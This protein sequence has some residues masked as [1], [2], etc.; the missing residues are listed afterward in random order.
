MSGGVLSKPATPPGQHNSRLQ[1]QSDLQAAGR[2]LAETSAQECSCLAWAIF[3][4]LERR[5]KQ[6]NGRWPSGWPRDALQFR[7]FIWDQIKKNMPRF[8]K[9]LRQNSQAT[10][11][12]LKKSDRTLVNLL[13]DKYSKPGRFMSTFEMMVASELLKEEGIIL[14]NYFTRGD[15]ANTLAVWEMPTSS[16]EHG[17]WVHVCPVD[18]T[19]LHVV[20]CNVLVNVHYERC[21]T[22]HRETGWKPGPLRE[23]M[24]ELASRAHTSL[25][26]FCIMP[27][28]NDRDAL[29]FEG[30]TEFTEEAKQLFRPMWEQ[31]R[32]VRRWAPRE[33]PI[34]VWTPTPTGSPSKSAESS[35][36][37]Q[38][39]F[40]ADLKRA[41]EES[42][43]TFS[44]EDDQRQ[45]MDRHEAAQID[46]II[47]KSKQEA[48]TRED[49]FRSEMEAVTQHMT[50]QVD[51]KALDVPGDGWCQQHA[52]LRCLCEVEPHNA[53]TVQTLREAQVSFMESEFEH[54]KDYAVDKEY[55]LN[56]AD[57]PGSW[58]RYC[59]G[60]RCRLCSID[61]ML[62]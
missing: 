53:W 15:F 40:D 54:Y 7:T 62:C 49:K 13:A 61:P 33:N 38:S 9:L 4:E 36:P 11:A 10:D 32:Q 50:A 26:Q 45:D 20:I 17:R 31:A 48:R 18:V 47:E 16:H 22:V 37:E 56:A 43:H 12:E 34:Q 29:G 58:Q 3:G 1:I 52:L 46:A 42:R 14:V 44:Q 25:R 2:A 24:V 57:D 8:G 35:P 23:H 39:A 51:R 6:H 41:L 21:P 55:E 19:P 27:V 60:Y 59:D 5:E 28:A 30:A